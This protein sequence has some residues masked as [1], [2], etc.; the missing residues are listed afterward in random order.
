MA[1]STKAPLTGTATAQVSE[2]YA[3]VAT[4]LERKAVAASVWNTTEIGVTT[5]PTDGVS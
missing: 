1:A 5:N 3:P 4:T 2:S